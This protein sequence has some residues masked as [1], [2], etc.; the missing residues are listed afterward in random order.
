MLD[1]IFLTVLVVLYTASHAVVL[2]LAK[3]GAKR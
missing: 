2:G 3:L 1:A